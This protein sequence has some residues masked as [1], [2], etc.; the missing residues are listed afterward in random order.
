MGLGLGLV[1]AGLA[2]ASC[3]KNATRL[4]GAGPPPAT[5]PAGPVEPMAN[6]HA[7]AMTGGTPGAPVEPVP[8]WTIGG[9]I[10]LVPEFAGK[11]GESDVLFVMARVP[12]QRM[13]VAVER[14]AAPTFPLAY[15]LHSG[16]SAGP[17][18]GPPPQLEIL[19]RLSRS[20]TAGPPQPG[21]LEGI[22]DGQAS[23]GATGVDFVVGK[24]Y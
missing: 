1:L 16:H 12:G 20:G 4:D 21:D 7:G 23:P 2:V 10:Q 14:F 24:Q 22:F 9:T 13:P 18:G 19:A 6:P 15:T 8:E 17:A 11:V 5:Q 3:G